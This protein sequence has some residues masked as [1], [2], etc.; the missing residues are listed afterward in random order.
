MTN[1]DPGPDQLVLPGMPEPVEKPAPEPVL[2]R[3]R[4]TVE[5]DVEVN[6]TRA[7][8]AYAKEFEATEGR[9]PIEKTSNF[10]WDLVTEAVDADCTVFG[11]NGDNEHI[12]KH[13][14]S[15]VDFDVR[16]KAEDQERLDGLTN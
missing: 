2:I 15:D 7:V 8:E 1:I 16:W 11:G 13:I 14:W 5:I 3:A 4:V 12:V 9:D 6:V 10:L